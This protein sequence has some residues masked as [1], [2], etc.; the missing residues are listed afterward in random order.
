MNR[1]HF[2]CMY[3]VVY[4]AIHKPRG[5]MSG[6]GPGAGGWSYDHIEK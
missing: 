1:V 5:Q 6:G 3:Y 4:G 2:L